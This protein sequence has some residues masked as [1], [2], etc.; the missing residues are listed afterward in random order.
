MGDKE[1]PG[2]VYRVAFI[3]RSNLVDNLLKD[4]MNTIDLN[5]NFS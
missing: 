4:T 1:I 3:S 5:Q 2:M